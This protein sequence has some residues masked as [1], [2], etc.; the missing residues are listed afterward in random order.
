MKV[1]PKHQKGGNLDAFFT[2]YVPVQIQATNQTSS[3]QRSSGNSQSSEKG[4]LTEKDFFDMLKDIDGLPNE[5]NA[6]VG[7]LMNT[8]RLS[9]LTGVDPGDLATTYLSN[10]YQ[11]K[12]ASQNKAAYDKAVE[13]ANKNGSM[14]EPAIS[15]DGKLVVQNADGKITTVSLS[16]Y[17]ENK[18]QYAPLTV[19]NLANLRAYSPELAYKSGIFDI[20]NN[21]VGF[22]SFQKLLDQA[23]ISLGSNK[24]SEK[25]ITDKQAL[26]GLE[27]LQSLPE[28]RKQEVLNQALDGNYAYLYTNDSNIQQVQSLINYLQAVIPDRMKTW[29]AWKSQTADKETASRTLISEYLS[30]RINTSRALTIT[31]PKATSSSSKSSAGEDPKEGQWVQMQ[32]GRGGNDSTFSILNNRTLLTVNGK[33]YGDTPGLDKHKSFNDYL[34]DSGIRK[35]I[36]NMNNITFGDT[37]ISSDSYNDM[38]VDAN[39]GAMMVTLP[40]TPEGKVDFSV[41]DTYTNIDNN[42]RGQ[43]LKPDSLEYNTQL[44]QELV[45]NGLGY[46]VDAQN[47][48][49][50]MSKFGHFLVLRGLTN[51]KAKIIKNGKKTDIDD[52][53][54]QYMIDSSD[55]SQLYDII[56]QTLSNK[57]TGEYKLDPNDWWIFEGGWDRIY[58]GNIFIPISMNTINGMNADENDIKSSTALQYEQNMQ[59]IQKANNQRPTGSDQ[60]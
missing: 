27:Y 12:V 42:L 1:T 38:I 29:A 55:D 36:K 15:M 43:G 54:S 7:N 49:I 11:V 17:F 14:A 28:E 46:L 33:Y 16:N 10:L 6:I 22:E 4:K 21:S 52:A 41:L 48:T 9:A 53:N 37:Q 24:Y 56:S 5:M 35:V 20:I 8:F 47:G 34:T 57:E 2:T 40:I 3:Q 59:Q 13:Q 51:S 32:V 50:D 60:L 23:Q 58:S 25:S 31:A 45:S 19:S 26:Q 30:G 39:G 18:D 44:V